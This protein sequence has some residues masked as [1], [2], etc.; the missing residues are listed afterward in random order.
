MHGARDGVPG[1]CVFP[2]TDGLD[3]AAW[4]VALCTK[5]SHALEM[6]VRR[7][8]ASLTPFGLIER[9]ASAPTDRIAEFLG[10][11]PVAGRRVTSSEASIRS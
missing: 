3:G 2:T 9:Y 7:L 8:A 10:P 6:C 4:D 1:L 5:L 11:A